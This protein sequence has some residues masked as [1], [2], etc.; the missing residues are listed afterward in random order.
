MSEGVRKIFCD[1]QVLKEDGWTTDPVLENK[2]MTFEGGCSIGSSVWWQGFEAVIIAYI[3]DDEI[4][5][6]WKLKWV[7]DLETCDLEHKE[8]LKAMKAWA[9]KEEKRKARLE[10]ISGGNKKIS[11]ALIG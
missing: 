3:R 9:N 1:R 2:D 6:L 10:T 11:P 8:L 4:G 7:N 5:D